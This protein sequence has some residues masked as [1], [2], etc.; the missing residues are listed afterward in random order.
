MLRPRRSW[1]LAKIT[2]S[3]F[4]PSAETSAS[5][6]RSDLAVCGLSVTRSL[7]G[8]PLCCRHAS[9]HSSSSLGGTSVCAG[10]WC[11]VEPWPMALVV[12]VR[13]EI[14]ISAASARGPPTS[15]CGVR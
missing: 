4:C 11:C 13:P 15:V 3:I 10:C 2:F 12:D 8:I 9:T 6:S 5:S 7:P 1:M 14:D